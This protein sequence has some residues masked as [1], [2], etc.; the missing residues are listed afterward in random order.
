MSDLTDALH[1]QHRQHVSR[2]KRG[3]VDDSFVDEI[4]ALIAK[5]REA[6][7][8]VADPAERSQVRALLRFWG[9]VVYDQTG[10]YPDTALQPL[11]PARAPVLEGEEPS[12]RRWPSLVWML[13]GGAATAIIAAGLVLVGWFSLPHDGAVETPMPVPTPT[14][15][16]FVSRVAVG[17][18][19]DEDGGLETATDTFCLGIADI[20]AEVALEGVEAGTLWRWE[21]QRAGEVVAG[22]AA[23]PWG[24][25]ERHVVRL[26][27][28]I[29][30]RLHGDSEG[31][32][33]GRYELLIYVGEHV[34]GAHSFR[35]LDVTPGVSNL[36]VA[37]VPELSGAAP[38][39]P[40][41]RVFQ[42]GL[43]VIYLSYEYEGF[44]PGLDISHV[45][46]REGEPS[47]ESAGAWLGASQGQAQVAFQAPAGGPFS[48]GSYEVIVIGSGEE[49]AR[50]AFRI[51]EIEQDAPE[52]VAPAFG[53]IAIALGVQPDGT[54]ILGVP[55]GGF[56]WNTKVVYAVFGYEG[57]T[58][59]LPWSALWMRNGEEVARQERLWDTEAA[60]AEGTHWIARYDEL[61]RV[62][63]GG[64][65][66]VTL[67][68]EN[69]AR[70]TAGFDIRYYVPPE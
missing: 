43:R 58:D 1:K 3:P 23:A 57:M 55:D 25:D 60:G 42:P 11:D 69:I 21:V 39:G 65:Y 15:L 13:V 46:S 47:Q 31:V 24:Q 59:G 64:S 27:R 2:M 33:P 54:P 8:V 9:N 12:R 29:N 56:D 51:G 4:H 44:C 38:G 41:E 30:V 6:G 62:L 37:D 35:V 34:V 67:Y 28:T 32:E 22:S 53:D 49:Q 66:S 45:L 40:G 5:L 7:A 14:P 63:P 18:G 68:I 19:L 61:G 52:E 26:G 20:V 36:Q 10:V 70:R 17:V 48:P 16:P 50:V